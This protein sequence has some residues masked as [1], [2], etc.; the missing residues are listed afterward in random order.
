MGYLGLSFGGPF[1]NEELV[2]E[3]LPPVR[4]QV[5]IATKFG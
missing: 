2:G 4:D 3:V 1:T 5:L